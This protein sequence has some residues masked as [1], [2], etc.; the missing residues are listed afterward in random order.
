MDS[1]VKSTEPGRA[2]IRYVCYAT[3]NLPLIPLLNL[4]E[5]TIQLTTFAPLSRN[6]GKDYEARRRHRA[7]EH[8]VFVKDC[9]VDTNNLFVYT[10][11]AVG[12]DDQAS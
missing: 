4:E 1:L 3:D 6:M 2:I 12:K 9:I 5:T 8:Q 7:T 10:D 11:A